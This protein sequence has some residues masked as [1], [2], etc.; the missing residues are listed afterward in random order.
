MSYIRQ[1]YHKRYASG[2]NANTYFE[3]QGQQRRGEGSGNTSRRTLN[4]HR[5]I[6]VHVDTHSTQDST[7]R[8]QDLGLTASRLLAPRCLRQRTSSRRLR[9][10]RSSKRGRRSWG[11]NCP[12]SPH[13]DQGFPQRTG[14]EIHR[15]NRLLAARTHIH[16]KHDTFVC[17][18]WFSCWKG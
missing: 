7:V 5:H 11:G 10:R 18:S 15:R 3:V 9:T 4:H 1:Q 13:A 2:N 12:T 17:E 8:P 16:T 6:H 14:R